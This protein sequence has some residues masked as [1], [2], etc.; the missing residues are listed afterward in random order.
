[1]KYIHKQ[2][3]KSSKGGLKDVAEQLHV[4]RIGEQH[5]AGSDSL[6]TSAIF[7]KMK[8]TF[9]QLG[10]FDENA[11]KW[12][13]HPLYTESLTEAAECSLEVIFMALAPH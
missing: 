12:V 8:Q 9:F 2:V 10:T 13:L 3:D 7:F 11:F 4:S 5:Q 1:M 6:L